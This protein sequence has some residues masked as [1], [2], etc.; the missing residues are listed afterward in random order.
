METIYN[1]E[2]DDEGEIKELVELYFDFK[3]THEDSFLILNPGSVGFPRDGVC[4]KRGDRQ[5]AKYLYLEVES[6]R[7]RV[8]FRF[9]SYYAQSIL[10]TLKD[11][12]YPDET[13]KMLEC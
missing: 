12:K 2:V 11:A 3:N 5:V 8:Q 4:C 13:R 7:L 1:P 10:K 9:A 6:T